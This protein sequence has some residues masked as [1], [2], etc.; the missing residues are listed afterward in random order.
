MEFSTKEKAVEKNI[1]IFPEISDERK[2]LVLEH[3]RKDLGSVENLAAV[4]ID[5]INGEKNRYCLRY[6]LKGSP[7]ERRRT[8]SADFPLR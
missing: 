2:R 5:R 7:F 1:K 8:I 3:I 4:R 6:A